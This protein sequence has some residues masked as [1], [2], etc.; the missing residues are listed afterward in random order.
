MACQSSPDTP[1]ILNLNDTGVNDYKDFINA[2]LGVCWPV[3][4]LSRKREE[5]IVKNL[6]QTASSQETMDENWLFQVRLDYNGAELVVLLQKQN[7]Y[8]VGYKGK[9]DTWILLQGNYCKEVLDDVEKLGGSG[10][11]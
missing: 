7:L 3:Y 9:D 1:P 4:R 10:K 11:K 8:L 5:V 2:I 6:R